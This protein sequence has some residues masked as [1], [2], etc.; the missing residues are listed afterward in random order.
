M[1]TELEKEEC[2]RKLR[3]ALSEDSPIDA[4]VLEIKNWIP[5]GMDRVVAMDLLKVIY[6]DASP[7][8]EEILEDV[9]DMVW[10]YCSPENRIFPS[11]K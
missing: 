5:C 2:L 7:E 11:Q 1:L 6:R 8:E 4:M 3:K 10:G 9:G